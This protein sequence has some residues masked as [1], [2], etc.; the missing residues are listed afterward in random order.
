VCAEEK[1]DWPW[2][3]AKEAESS[4]GAEQNPL[5]AFIDMDDWQ[6]LR[7]HLQADAT[8]S[9]ALKQKFCLVCGRRA[10]DLLGDVSTLGVVLGSGAA[11][12]LTGAAAGG[13]AVAFGAVAVPASLAAAASGSGVV[14]GVATVALANPFGLAILCAG[15]VCLGM[16]LAVAK[17][18]SMADSHRTKTCYGDCKSF[19]PKEYAKLKEKK[20]CFVVLEYSEE[21]CHAEELLPSFAKPL[22]LLSDLLLAAPLPA[23]PTVPPRALLIERMPGESAKAKVQFML[24]MPGESAKAKA[25]FL[26]AMPGQSGDEKPSALTSLQTIIALQ[27]KRPSAQLVSASATVKELLEEDQCAE[28]VS[29]IAKEFGTPPEH[30]AC[31]ADMKLSDLARRLDPGYTQLGAAITPLLEAVFSAQMPAGFGTA[32]ARKYLK[33][34]CGPEACCDSVDAIMLRVPLIVPASAFPTDEAARVFLDQVAI[35]V[36]TEAK[37]HFILAMPGDSPQEKAQFIKDMPG[38]STEAKARFISAVPGSS[39]K[40][41]AHFIYTMPGNSPQ[42]K[43]KFICEMMMC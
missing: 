17:L 27:L 35:A 40:A 10:G 13:G 20:D 41:K 3:P 28:A 30:A 6:G 16:G 4:K 26:W 14:A 25:Q 19:S 7:Q 31:Y 9:K 24:D 22:D 37:V 23:E 38:E 39:T 15:V 43:A 8:A 18:S 36:A 5:K 12:G 1:R 32:T 11:A 33:A 29:T 34:K 21:L 2:Q 42:E